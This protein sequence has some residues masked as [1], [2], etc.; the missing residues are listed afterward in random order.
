MATLQSKIS[1]SSTE[2]KSNLADMSE[3]VS[4]LQEK[5][6]VIIRTGESYCR[7]IGSIN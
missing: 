6:A 1:T 7:A 5:F 4:D 3:L 2:F